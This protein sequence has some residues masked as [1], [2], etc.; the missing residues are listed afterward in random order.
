M[1]G[2]RNRSTGATNNMD[3]GINRIVEGT[4]IEGVIKSESSLRIDG[5]FT[6]ELITKGRLVVGPKGKVQGTVHCLC[7]ASL[8]RPSRNKLLKRNSNKSLRFMNLGITLGVAIAVGVFGGQALDEKF[9]LEQ[10]L[11]TV[12]GSLLS[13][14]AGLWIVI[15]DLNR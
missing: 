7:C 6:G 10:P 3:N 14:A 1:I 15:K 12:A 4:V 8:L 2:S 11:L 5:E 9:N 13:I